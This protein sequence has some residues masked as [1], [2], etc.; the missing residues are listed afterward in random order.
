VVSVAETGE[1]WMRTHEGLV[2]VRLA[3]FAGLVPVV[4][5]VKLGEL[6]GR[7]AERAAVAKTMPVVGPLY[8]AAVS[9]GRC[10]RKGCHHLATRI[11]HG[12]PRAEG[13]GHAPDNLSGLCEECHAELH[14]D[15]IANPQDHPSEWTNILPGQRP[16]PGA[17][18]RAYQRLRQEALHQGFRVA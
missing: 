17:V 10:Q 1:S 9:G 14:G 3:D 6:H 15:L 2:P 7:L 12:V 18:N 4:E 13:G 5:V 16:E 11:H 8:V